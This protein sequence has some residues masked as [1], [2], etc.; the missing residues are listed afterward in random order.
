MPKNLVIVESPAKAKTIG[1]Y[2]GQDYEVVASVGHVR[3][4][5]SKTMAVDIQNDFK[6]EYE[7]MPG[8]KSII[9]NLKKLAK[10]A[11]IVYLATD[12]DREGEAISWHILE[13]LTTKTIA[14][15]VIFHEITENGIKEAFDNPTTLNMGLVNAQQAR[16]VLDRVVGYELSPLLW[17]KF[18]SGYKLGLSAGR[19]QSVALKLIVEREKSIRSF[20]PEEYWIIS[21]GLTKEE[22]KKK[23][24][25]NARIS[26]S[27]KYSGEET[28][29][30][31][32]DL[33]LCIFKVDTVIQKTSKLKPPAP[34]ITSTLQQEAS[35]KIGGFSVSRTMRVAQQ[36]YEGI[37]LGSDAETGLITYMRTDS[38]ILSATATVEINDFIRD[39]YGDKYLGTGTRRNSRKSIVAAQEAHEAIRPTSINRTPEQIGKYLTSEQT[40]LYTLIWKR[41]LASRMAETVN[42]IT[43]VNI[44]AEKSSAVM[45]KF[46]CSGSEVEFDGYMKIYNIGN[47][48]PE[49]S[50]E[51]EDSSVEIEKFQKIPKLTEGQYLVLKNVNNDQ[52]FT[53]PAPRYTQATFVKTLEESGIGRPSTYVSIMA[54]LEGRNYCSLENGRYV[55]EPLGMAIVDQLDPYF[56]NIM[57]VDFTA[58]METNLDDIASGNKEWVTVLKEFYDPYRK[59]FSIAESSMPKI[60]VQTL[61]GESCPECE[62]PLAE[63]IGRNGKFIACTGFPECKFSR[64]YQIHTGVAC[65]KCQGSLVQRKGKRGGRIF[66][67]CSNYPACD[68]LLRQKPITIPCPVCKSILVMKN[69]R[70]V[71][72]SSCDFNGDLEGL[73]A[74]KGSSSEVTV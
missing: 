44:L 38:T 10:N 45:Y 64:P 70:S 71:S 9:Q 18:T 3:D 26:G 29:A 24:D 31:A 57:D 49:E 39:K 40:A 48:E 13:S 55:A 73:D 52:K 7:I 11:E 27:K 34:F 68:F 36:L 35:R 5:P 21:I 2:L 74:L 8:K 59:L 4:L 1:R 41:A 69:S 23:I 16:R 50:T 33:P 25:F 58:K 32:D 56:P 63:K 6:P 17:K 30:I 65:P 19:V 72:C 66:Y 42:R 60:T 61:T 62:R 47:D 51:E 67:G 46:F 54:T 53:R 43:T 15:R 28:K 37:A 14:K 12:P 20:I 22:N